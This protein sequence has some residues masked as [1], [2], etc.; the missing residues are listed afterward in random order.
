MDKPLESHFVSHVAYTMALE[1]HVD[2][3]TEKLRV[4]EEELNRIH[5]VAAPYD[6]GIKFGY[7][8]DIAIDA[9]AKIREVK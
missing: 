4:A 2:A 3:L 8:K 7:I 6:D 5:D 9:L 1:K